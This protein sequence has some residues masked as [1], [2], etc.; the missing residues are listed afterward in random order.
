[1]STA[2]TEKQIQMTEDP[3]NVWMT[4]VQLRRFKPKRE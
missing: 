1:M 4:N 3:Q 2:Q